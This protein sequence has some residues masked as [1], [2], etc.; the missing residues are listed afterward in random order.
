MSL[1][2]PNFNVYSV[3]SGARD[4]KIYQSL[5]IWTT[6]ATGSLRHHGAETPS[7]S[8]VAQDWRSTAAA[9]AQ[10]QTEAAV[11]VCSAA[12]RHRNCAVSTLTRVVLIAL[13][14]YSETCRTLHRDMMLVSAIITNSDNYYCILPHRLPHTL[15]L[16]GIMRLKDNYYKRT[17]KHTH[18]HNVRCIL[19]CVFQYA[20]IYASSACVDVGR[21][22]LPINRELKILFK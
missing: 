3:W 11:D 18:G 6:V 12:W 19:L 20:V 8:H 7:W 16:P 15:S 21:W 10:G 17:S 22:S 14:V 2:A 4:S 9:A 5:S 13:T 1:A